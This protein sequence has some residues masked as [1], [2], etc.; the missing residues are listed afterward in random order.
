MGAEVSSQAKSNAVSSGVLNLND[1]IAPS[2]LLFTPDHARVGSERYVRSF[3]VT[4]VP[5]QVMVGWLDDLYAF[6]DV[7]VALHLEPVDEFQVINNLTDKITELEA[8]LM[9]DEKSGSHRNVSLLQEAARDAWQLRAEIQT[10]RNKMYWVTIVFSVAAP[11]LET[12]NRASKVVQERMGGRAIH[13][14]DAFLR[15]S[16]GLKSVVPLNQNFV[17]DIKRNFDLGAATAL[18]PFAGADLAHPGGVFLGVNMITG[19][20]VFYNSFIGPPVLTNQHMGV[21]ATSGAGKTT[22]IRLLTAR[23]AIQGVRTLVLDPEGDYKLLCE[24]AGG[25]YVPL[26]SGQPSGINPFDIDPMDNLVNISEK[27]ADI[28]GLV[29]VMI[30]GVGGELSPEENIILEDVLRQEYE[31]KGITEDPASLY[32][33]ESA[34][35]DGM[36]QAGKVKK[37]MPTLTSLWERLDTLGKKTERLCLLLKPYLRGSSL[38]IFDCETKVNLAGAP[39]IVFDLYRLEENF[40][41]PFAMHVVLDWVWETWV[42][43]DREPKRLICDEAWLFLKYRDTMAFLENLARRGRKRNCSLCVATQ[44]F[45]EFKRSEEGQSVISNLDTLVLMQQNAEEIDSVA[46]VFKLSDGQKSFLR[47]VGVGEA[48][49]RA[50]KQV[51]AC[52]VIASEEEWAFINPLPTVQAG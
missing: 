44:R 12:L 7:D 45:G 41:R 4:A 1:I 36:Y 19:A 48:L 46:E 37:Q 35:K 43:A 50:G 18:F 16:E 14:R 26:I 24:I 20:P 22:L 29:R 31:S 52:Q 32:T 13:V 40:L 23:S 30:Q 28:K 27:V 49:I 42:K 51:A 8:Q 25:V 10:N 15:Q 11:D 39:I 6:G 17:K 34:L 9:L 5:S 2:G 33:M 21:I 3:Y 47:K 38:G